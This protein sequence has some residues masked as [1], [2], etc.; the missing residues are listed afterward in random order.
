MYIWIRSL[1][2]NHYCTPK[3][4]LCLRLQ[5][6]V[7]VFSL[8]HY[9]PFISFYAKTCKNRIFDWLTSMWTS[10]QETLTLTFPIGKSKHKQS[11]IWIYIFQRQRISYHKRSFKNA[12]TRWD[13]L[14][15]KGSPKLLFQVSKEVK[16]MHIKIKQPVV[17]KFDLRITLSSWTDDLPSHTLRRVKQLSKC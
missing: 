10:N 6:L 4:S 13:P 7:S 9:K 17:H 5:V 14:N 8:H 11:K 12:P 15:K 2:C 1:K 16:F 3:F